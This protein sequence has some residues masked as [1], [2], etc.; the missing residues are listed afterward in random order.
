MTLTFQVGLQ[1]K[2]GQP[3]Y[4]SLGASCHVEIQLDSSLD[5]IDVFQRRIK[6]AFAACRGSV[7]DELAQQQQAAVRQPPAPHSNH[8]SDDAGPTSHAEFQASE[9]QLNYAERL[10]SDVDGLGGFDLFV[11]RMTGKPVSE[12]T[13][14]DASS[15]IDQLQAVRAGVL[16]VEE[17]IN[18]VPS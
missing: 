17:I 5:D 10:A 1:K 7:N 9:K 2:I 11:K 12:L 6:E 18:G 13:R 8:R 15:L 14:L 3:G 4:G 16:Q